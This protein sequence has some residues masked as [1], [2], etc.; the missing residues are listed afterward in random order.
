MG[1]VYKSYMDKNFNNFIKIF[2]IGGSFE[3]IFK[4]KYTYIIL[5]IY[6]YFAIIINFY[7]SIGFLYIK[8]KCIK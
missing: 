4:T 1:S 3:T 6:A 8:F 7:I 5:P 2:M